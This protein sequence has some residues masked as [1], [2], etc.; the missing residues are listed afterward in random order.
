MVADDASGAITIQLTA[1]DPEFPIKLTLPPAS[2]LPADSTPH[3][4]GTAP[5]PGTGAYRITEYDPGTLLRVQ[6]N[7]FFKPWSEEAQPDGWPDE[8]TEEF[9]FGG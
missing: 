6:R 1:P 8:I 3:D 5:L 4:S 7:P 2:I 9:G